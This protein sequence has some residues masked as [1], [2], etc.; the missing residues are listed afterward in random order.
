[1]S[2]PSRNFYRQGLELNTTYRLVGDVVQIWFVSAREGR[3]HEQLANSVPLATLDP[4]LLPL[5]EGYTP[6][7]PP[8]TAAEPRFNFQKPKA[9]G[10]NR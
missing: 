5:V 4:E 7:A 2:D 9:A 8:P 3:Q 6:P 10:D 1:M